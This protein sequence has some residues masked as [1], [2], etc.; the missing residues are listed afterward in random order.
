[1]RDSAI[2]SAK[3]ARRWQMGHPWIFRSDVTSRPESP[4]GVVHVRERSGRPLG[5]AL[6]SPASEIS[7]RMID[8]D[9]RVPI[10]ARW[11][12]ARLERAIERRGDVGRTRS[13]YRLVHGEGDG[14]PSLICDRYD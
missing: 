3:G 6:W 12:R 11:W 13:A 1:M 7:L 14:C 2:V 8:R 4:A 10:D 9:P 5:S